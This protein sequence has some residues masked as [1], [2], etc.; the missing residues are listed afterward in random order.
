M[1]KQPIEDQIFKEGLSC[2]GKTFNGARH[3]YLTLSISN[4]DL[5]S[6]VVST[7]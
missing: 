2:L 6:I 5:V 7:F 4:K 1:S 3:A